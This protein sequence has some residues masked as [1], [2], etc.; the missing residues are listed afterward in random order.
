MF[1]FT[2]GG[3]MKR[4]SVAFAVSL[5]FASSLMAQ[6]I[7][8]DV[9]TPQPPDVVI[10]PGTDAE[11]VMSIVGGKGGNSTGGKGGTGSKI[12]I[13]AGDGGNGSGGAGNGDGGNIILLPGLA[14][15]GGDA[16]GT[17]GKVGIGTTTP[18]QMLSVQ[19]GMNIDQANLNAGFS[20]TPGLTF[21]SGS[22]E[23]ITSQRSG[24]GPGMNG[25]DFYTSGTKRMSIS[26]TGTDTIGGTLIKPT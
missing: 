8:L 2:Q 15:T 1:A 14:G 6:P 22:N 17:A 3:S 10:G 19:G 13:Q 20:P 16:A 11:Q 18:Q 12:L 24:G 9:A 21:G 25:L 5:L 7:K 26:S 23:G 4:A